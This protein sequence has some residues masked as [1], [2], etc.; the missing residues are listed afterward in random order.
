MSSPISSASIAIVGATGVVGQECLR[1]LEERGVGADR[2]KPL[3][4]ERSAGSRL[5]YGGGAIEVRELTPSAFNGVDVAFFAASGS[6]AREFVPIAARAGALVVDKSS[7]FR[8]EADVPLVVPEVNPEDI[9]WNR[10]IIANPNCCTVPLTV[11]LNAIREHAGLRRVRVATYQSASGAGKALVEELAEQT[12]AIARG[13]A[14]E[15]H[16]YPK[17]L[18]YNVVPGGWPMLEDG[19][20]EEETKIVEETR[21]ILHMPQLPV[22]ATCVRV[23]VPISHGEAVFLETDRPIDAEEARSIFA[24]SPG[25]VLVDDPNGQVYP[26]PMEVAG[27]DE[28]YIGRVRRDLAADAGLAFWVVSD[29]LRKGAA[30]NAIQV[31]EAAMAMGVLS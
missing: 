6:V 5:S 13:A 24:S 10:G 28:V 29:N 8:M 7:V 12:S 2:I 9:E 16:S 26:T 11:A 31:A 17:P 21:K 23:P 22:A 14:P 15:A 20:N 3:A 27:T 1:I 4:S 19:Y 18:A 25:I 30:L